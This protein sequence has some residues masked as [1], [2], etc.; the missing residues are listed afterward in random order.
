MFKSIVKKIF[1]VPVSA[2]KSA[3]SANGEF[4]LKKT[5]YGLVRVEFA[6]IKKISERALE[7]VAG[8]QK[9]ELSVE[10]LSEANPMRIRLEV[11][12][13]EGYSAPRISEA[14]DKAINSALK[15][16]LQLEFYVPV[17]VKVMEIA[18]VVAPKRRR[19]R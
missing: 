19:V 2:V 14:A 9:S 11:S 1:S 6:V 15:E 8:I 7:S 13:V 12:L 5:D 16:F 17:D 10:K 3:R 4:L 18:Q